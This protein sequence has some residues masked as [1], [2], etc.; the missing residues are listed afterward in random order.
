[1]M[2][3]HLQSYINALI[4]NRAVSAT[5]IETL[6]HTLFP[7]GIR[8]KAEAD[9]LIAVDRL[10]QPQDEWSYTVTALVVDFVLSGE[11]RKGAVSSETAHWL[12]ATLDVGELT[13]TAI[14]IA[15]EV[16]KQADVVD[17]VL[18]D[19]MLRRVRYYPKAR[20][21]ERNAA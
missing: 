20:Y 9:A 19:F 6:N 21:S 2:D 13:K 3:S 4:E 17:P 18:V 10:I 14:W 16:V 11:R 5:D 1:M 7:K 8:S 15:E 12:V